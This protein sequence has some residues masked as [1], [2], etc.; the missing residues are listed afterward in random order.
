MSPA[1]TPGAGVLAEGY[2]PG[3]SPQEFGWIR[4]FLFRQTGIQLK[5]GKQPMVVGRLNRRLR[6]HGFT[7]F[8]E[9]F[10]FIVEDEVERTLAVDLLTT[11]E[12]Y[13]FREPDHFTFL[14]DLMAAR[15]DSRPVRVWSAAS[16]SGEEAYTIAMTLDSA[17]RG[18]D[19]EILGTDISTRVLD[20]AARGLYPIDAAQKIPRHLLRQYCL[21]GTDDFDGFLAISPELRR[22]VRF[23]Q[24]N[25]IE[26]YPE[27]GS[28]D[29]IFLRN[30]MIYFGL[31]T[32]Q[33]IIDQLEPLLRPG[34][35]L[36]ISHS[37]T[38]NGLS[39]SLRPVVPSVYTNGSGS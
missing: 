3:L 36:F 26:P 12:T 23:R 22:R 39:T 32:K 24:L 33:L 6:H 8:G 34:G 19:F 11:N 20:T 27:L 29:V 16:S 35:H 17:L 9:Y 38:L 10:R 37:E 14:R 5:D 31:E 1:R 7:T 4:D 30:V 15:K 25:L 21:R 13:F 2:G 18:G 28:F